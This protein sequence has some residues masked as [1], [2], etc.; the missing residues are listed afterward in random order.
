MTRRLLLGVSVA[1]L[2]LALA[3]PPS[4]EAAHRRSRSRGYRNSYSYVSP[5]YRYGYGPYVAPGYYYGYSYGRPGYYSSRYDPYYSSRY[6]PYY[7]SGRY[8]APYP[9]RRHSPYKRYYYRGRWR[10]HI[11]IHLGF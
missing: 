10:P 4:A 5:G 11:S 2:M 9:Y 1:G 3:A 8:Y 6:D 7:Y